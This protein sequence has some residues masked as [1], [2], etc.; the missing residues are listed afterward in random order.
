MKAAGSQQLDWSSPTA[1]ILRN[2]FGDEGPLDIVDLS[3]R[4]AQDAD[5]RRICVALDRRGAAPDIDPDDVDIALTCAPSAPR[6]WVCADVEDLDAALTLLKRRVSENP[7]SS[8]AARSVIS[9]GLQLPFGAAL[10]IE[11][12]AYSMLLAGDAFA[13]WRSQNPAPPGRT[14]ARRVS[15]RKSGEGWVVELDRQS[16]RNAFD[17]AMRDAL[18]QALEDLS[19]DPHGEP[20]ELRGAGPCFSAGGDLAEFGVAADPGLAHL[21]RIRQSPARLVHGL[22]ARVTAS[23]H[24]ACIGAGIEIPAAAGRVVAAADT[25]IRLPEIGMGLIPGAGGCVTIPRRI[26]H[27]R[28]LFL[29]LSGR[30][31]DAATALS[32]GLVDHIEDGAP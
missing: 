30:S 9:A 11:S 23:I 21:I 17:A 2:V 14:S 18:V 20:V 16:S 24:G 3:D 5:K 8:F 4:S 13:L 15:V 10:E 19:A 26:G 6:P 12:L 25:K 22:R 1:D 31:I 27:H 29:A 7:V 32:W 28:A